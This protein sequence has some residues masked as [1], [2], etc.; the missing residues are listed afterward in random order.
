MNPLA[1]LGLTHILFGLLLIAA[2][3]KEK[4]DTIL[5]LWL[6]VLLQ[7][8]L[9]QAI[10]S[11]STARTFLIRIN[12]QA[13][14]LLNGP[15]L[16]LYM[17]EV[18]GGKNSSPPYLP[19][20]I[21]FAFFYL[22]LVIHPSPLAPGGPETKPYDSFFLLSHFGTVNLLIFAAYSFFS[23]RA[24]KIHR[25]RIKETF[26]FQNREISLIW[27]SLLPYIFIALFCA[28]IVLE[29]T[30]L[31]SGEKAESLHLTIFLLFA[32][33]LIFF[34]LRQKQVFPEKKKAKKVKPAEEKAEKDLSEE[35]DKILLEKL[36]TLMEKEQLYLNPTLSVY[37]LA[38][39]SEISRHRISALLNEKQ[40][41]NFFQFVNRYRLEEVCRRFKEDPENRHNILEHAFDSGFNSKSSFNSLFKEH[42]GQTP[43]QYRKAQK[44]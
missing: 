11:G 36:T 10:L 37:D 35:K 29:R 43:S 38:Q 22:I 2:K 9:Q 15:F 44:S 28:V 16:Y 39:A 33:Y 14:T 6:L 31:G 7:P 41:M 20:F 30:P 12:N 34:G 25:K 18:T 32:L 40:S 5:I 17:K 42:Y 21:P 27:L 24:L 8:F 4:A 26:A 23:L 3:K 1:L 13:F 19:H